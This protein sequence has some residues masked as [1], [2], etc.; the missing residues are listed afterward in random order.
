MGQIRYLTSG[1]VCPPDCR[2]SIH[3]QY[4]SLHNIHFLSSWSYI[5]VLLELKGF[6]CYF[7]KWQL[8]PFNSKVTNFDDTSL[9]SVHRQSALLYNDWYMALTLQ[10]MRFVVYILIFWVWKLWICWCNFHYKLMKNIRFFNSSKIAKLYSYDNV[11]FD[12]LFVN[13]ALFL[14]YM[15]I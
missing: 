13:V 5:I 12:N 3:H 9:Q 11:I 10:Y 6:N 7:V 1:V 8:H 4:S 14:T 2:A 15:F